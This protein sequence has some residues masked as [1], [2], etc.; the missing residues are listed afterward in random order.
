MRTEPGEQ[1][2]VIRLVTQALGFL[3]LEK[4]RRLH[5]IY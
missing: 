1:M 4:I 5:L 3:L 2:L